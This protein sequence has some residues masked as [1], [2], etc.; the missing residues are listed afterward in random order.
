MTTSSEVSDAREAPLARTLQI[1]RPAA[2]PLSLAIVLG[3]G[4]IASAIGL[5]ATSAW[6][7]S[8]AAE[9]PSVAALALAVVGVRL[10]AVSRG[11]FRYGERL[12][13]HEATLRSLTELRVSVYRSLD[14]LAPSGLP[15]FRRGD[16]QARLVADVDALQDVM[17]RVIPPW[18]VAVIVGGATVTFLWWLLPAAALVLAMTLLIAATFVPMLSLWLA[19]R[20][21]SSQATIRGELSSSVVDL[22]EG[23]PDLVAYG[24]TQ[25]QLSRVTAADSGLTRVS[26][27]SAF[28]VGVSSGLTAL[29]TG[30][31]VWTTLLV[32][33]PAVYDGGL[34]GVQLAILV[35]TPLAAFEL[36]AGLPAATQSLARARRSAARVFD[37]LDAPA[38][39][40]DPPEAAAA[41][42]PPHTIRME[43]LRVRYPART[44]WAL[45]GID[46]HLPPGRRVGIVGPSGA[47]KSTLANVLVRFV[48]YGSGSATLDGVEIG[49]LAANDMRQVVGLV[50]QDAHIFDATLRDNLLIGRSDATDHELWKVLELVRLR[51][52]VERLPSQLETAVGI[53]GATLSGGQR[54]RIAV[55]RTLLA[56][57]PVLIL[58]EPGE[59]LETT[60]ADALI[61]DSLR[62][63]DGRTIL[64]ITHR[65]APLPA[66]DEVLVLEAGRIVER[67]S[68]ADLITRGGRYT[69]LWE[70]ECNGGLRP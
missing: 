36:V 10:F 16:L 40:I 55:A 5:I 47:G 65:L 43:R 38:P 42:R 15:G 57:F 45:D 8:R 19:R 27:A 58:D 66:M 6:L 32:A 29:L 31:A 50:E 67:G 62:A 25:H 37:V 17:L 48:P 11:L 18:A 54:Q 7:I 56:D 20:S 49:H 22:V 21:E 39:V 26:A 35:L 51:E 12:V 69:K 33:V 23:A 59:H 1:A 13:G 53:H 68:H 52:W 14:R 4:T 3:A 70:R 30:L 61:A 44:S 9:Q 24:A 46:L 63:M 64:L 2:R 60:A 34:P 28:T 41:P